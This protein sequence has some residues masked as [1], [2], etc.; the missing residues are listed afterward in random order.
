MITCVSCKNKTS[1]E[2]CNNRPL[3]GLIL[4]GKHVRMKNPRMWKDVNNLDRKAVMI[5]KIWRGYAIRNWLKLAGPGVLK[6]AICHNDEELVT[7]DEKKSVSPFDYFAFEE[8]G[9]IYWFDIRSLAENSMMKLEPTNPY[10]RE[11]LSFDTRKR[12]RQICIR[13]HRNKLENIHS[14][15]K[16]QT[17][18][19]IIESTWIYICQII[20]ENGFFDMSH[21]YFTSLN[22]TQLY[23]F[24]TMLR[25]DMVAWA[26]EHTNSESRRHRYVYWLKRLL[27]HY[28]MRVE[29]LR[30]SF[31]TSRVLVTILNDCAEEYPICFMIMSA[32][33]RL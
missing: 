11:P 9:K 30:L 29:A 7:L 25:Q 28:S 23:I 24:T 33:H 1:D 19:E 3:K 18:N 4:C 12:M 22:R 15:E 16:K 26:A 6:R 10:T 20:T 2:R 17:V 8:N 31:I 27:D 5:Q 13:R 21:L 14:T 32:L